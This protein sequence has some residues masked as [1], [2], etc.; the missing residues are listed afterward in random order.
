M[1]T[2]PVDDEFCPLGCEHTWHGEP[3]RLR[4]HLH[5]DLT[6][7]MYPECRCPGVFGVLNDRDD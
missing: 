5:A 1:A 6:R 4:V 2:V 3:C 7:R